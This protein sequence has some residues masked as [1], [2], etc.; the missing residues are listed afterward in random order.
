MR[1]LL[2]LVSFSSLLASGVYAAPPAKEAEKTPLNGLRTWFK[3]LREGLS[4]SSV[5]GAYQKRNVTAVAAVRGEEQKSAELE[6]VEWKGSRSAAGKARKAEQK[7]LDVAVALIEQGQIEDGLK[8]IDAFEEAHP[9]SSFKKDLPEIRAKAKEYQAALA[10]GGEV[11]P[12][13][14]ESAPSGKD[15]APAP[16]VPASAKP[17]KANTR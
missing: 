1:K 8:A 12:A 10:A 5:S 13:A 17:A 3:H 11:A 6:T 16:A 14:P 9:K 15:A 4:E 7:E 2:F